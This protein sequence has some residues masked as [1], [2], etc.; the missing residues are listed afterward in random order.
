M[1]RE[2]KHKEVA[3][4]VDMFSSSKGI[5]LT[6]FTGLNV[7]LLT[8]LRRKLSD[9]S[10]SYRVVKNTLAARAAKQAGL[11]QLIEFLEGPTAIAYTDGDPVIPAKA[12]SEFLRE[13][14]RPRFKSALIEGQMYSAEQV[15][16]LATLP[17]KEELLSKV[18]WGIGSP[19]S[20][21]VAS[22]QGILQALVATLD[23]IAKQRE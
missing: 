9:C 22:L 13:N 2:E 10:V 8:K 4:L 1:A 14:Q 11:D 20:G 19:L 15:A 17:S 21:L 12:I 3:R 6:D 5:Y 7:E 16:S 23:A 18:L